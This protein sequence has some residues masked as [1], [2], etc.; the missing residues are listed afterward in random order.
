MKQNIFLITIDALRSDYIYNHNGNLHPFLSDLMDD[1][2]VFKNTISPASPTALAF[3]GLFANLSALEAKKKGG[4][5]PPSSKTLAE[6]FNDL[7]YF[8]IGFS[9]N[10]HLTRIQGYDKGFDYFYDGLGH[11][12]DLNKKDKFKIKKTRDTGDLNIKKKVMHTIKK[13]FDISLKRGKHI[14]GPLLNLINVRGYEPF[15]SLFKKIKNILDKYPKKR[16]LF[17][18]A[19]IMEVHSPYYI[20][21]DIFSKLGEKKIPRWEQQWLRH[22]RLNAKLLDGEYLS[23]KEMEKIKI[24]YRCGIRE[25]D[26]YLNQ[27]FNY[28]KMN[29]FLDNGCLA[30]TSDH[31]DNL[32]DHQLT[33]HADIYNSVLKVPLLIYNRNNNEQVDDVF[34]NIHLGKLLLDIAKNKS[35]KKQLDNYTGMAIS[36]RGR[37]YAIQDRKY[38]ILWESDSGKKRYYELTDGYESRQITNPKGHELS[39]LNKLFLNLESHINQINDEEKEKI[40]G[41]LNKISL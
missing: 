27:F 22:K 18:W 37:K 2:L 40:T 17:L 14:F 41:A 16:P 32:G 3:P 34:S 30:L 33:G 15:P 21:P 39:H 8:T 9:N 6:K 36:M 4:G 28:L 13:E 10:P 19:H 25:V 26:S 23:Y 38:K 7:G 1:S 29:D 35:L 5:I 24:L 12:T 20:S 11:N 31:G